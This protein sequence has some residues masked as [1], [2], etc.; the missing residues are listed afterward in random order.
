MNVIPRS[1]W[2][3]SLTWDSTIHPSHRHFDGDLQSLRATRYSPSDTSP[4][5]SCVRVGAVWIDSGHSGASCNRILYGTGFAS[6]DKFNFE[7]ISPVMQIE[8]NG[9]I[10][11]INCFCVQVCV[12]VFE[13]ISSQFLEEERW[14]RKEIRK[15]ETNGITYISGF[16]FSYF[17]NHISKQDWFK[18]G[19][20]QWGDCY[21]EPK[22]W[23][24]FSSGM[25]HRAVLQKCTDFSEELAAS[26]IRIRINKNS[27]LAFSYCF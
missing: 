8:G 27:I 16:M 5:I 2:F 26:I 11:H 25:W 7:N 19:P 21:S 13:C 3:W 23:S 18:N 17:Q 10:E 12:F 14:R 20:S 4:E 22:M 1:F 15:Y 6:V 9:P 24:F